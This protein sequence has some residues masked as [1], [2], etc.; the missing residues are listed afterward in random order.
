M[1]IT[2]MKTL[3]DITSAFVGEN[4]NFFT[5]D[6][7][8]EL[9]RNVLI[10]I[11]P[12][13]NA[14]FLHKICIQ[15]P[16]LKCSE[17]WKKH[18]QK[19][20][21]FWNR[22]G[23]TYSTVFSDSER[24]E[25]FH[26]VYL[27]KHFLDL[28]NYCCL[29]VHVPDPIGLLNCPLHKMKPWNIVTSCSLQSAKYINELVH[30]AQY[31]E[32]VS[33]VGSQCSWICCQKDV[34][35]RLLG[36][37]KIVNLH[38]VNDTYYDGVRTLLW[39]LINRGK[40]EEANF[41][42]ITLT[43]SLTNLHDLLKICAGVNVSRTMKTDT[44]LK[45]SRKRPRESID[46]GSSSYTTSVILDSGYDSPLSKRV[47]VRLDD[48]DNS[49]DNS[50]VSITTTE[51]VPRIVDVIDFTGVQ[52]DDPQPSTSS[53]NSV[54]V[55]E[56]FSYE[57]EEYFGQEA[58]GQLEMEDMSALYVSGNFM[59]GRSIS[60]DS[61][62]YDEAVQPI[63]RKSSSR[64]RSYP[65]IPLVDS[66]VS[67]VDSKHPVKGVSSFSITCT[68]LAG[69]LQVLPTW[70][71]LRKISLS[72]ATIDDERM[73]TAI[74]D[75]VRSHQ[76]SHLVLDDCYLSDQFYQR[77]LSV[78]QNHFK[79]PEHALELI[80]IQASSS[81]LSIL[82]T[83]KYKEI[84]YGVK[85]LNLSMNT[86]LSSGL[87]ALTTL[88]K[89]D[90]SLTHLKLNGCFLQESQVCLLLQALSERNQLQMLGLSG[91]L[92]AESTVESELLNF[93]SKVTTLTNLTMNYSRLRPQFVSDPAFVSAIK[94]H[95]NLKELSM[96]NNHLGVS[97]CQFLQ[98][99]CNQ[100][101]FSLRHLNIGYNW[102]K[103]E[104][105]IKCV[106]EIQACQLRDGDC[107]PVLQSL[108]LSGNR[109]KPRDFETV[110]NL[111]KTLV[112]ELEI[113]SID[114]SVPHAEHVG[115]M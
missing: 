44:P 48:P 59:A 74:L 15:I 12:Y 20:W 13:L 33:L 105:M 67:Q 1:T 54:T 113:S 47:C 46:E 51:E 88:V 102:I 40:L 101:Q 57:E 93:L 3:L 65:P 75:K 58:G 21:N 97:A 30:Y 71:D 70:S 6:I 63:V 73:M 85:K 89:Y 24:T 34:L 69:L 83:E 19:R 8:Q 106:K 32:S 56:E 108:I 50:V 103:V 16:D 81:P 43:L 39:N 92:V 64:R 7:L 78:L 4:S 55:S 45:R 53:G 42:S 61:D 114:Y 82:S 96:K 11:L 90:I 80:D 27:I 52:N 109:L 91:N 17:L 86:F 10:N 94:T 62:L 18:V 66:F 107:Y 87:E 98:S 26:K 37:T 104:D 72:H 111:F 76:L 84:Q 41:S 95:Q 23:S 22:V 35:S 77:L 115:Q 36:A 38:V 31:A 9:P 28:L 2:I 79:S 29:N 49:L 5:P 99:L 14:A 25:D 112:V 60:N 68:N 110:R 100:G